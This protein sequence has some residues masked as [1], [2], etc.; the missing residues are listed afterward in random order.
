MGLYLS[1]HIFKID[2][3]YLHLS[4]SLNELVVGL[5]PEVNATVFIRNDGE[6]SYSTRLTFLHPSSLSYRR[7]LLVQ[8]S[9]K[10]SETPEWKGWGMAKDDT[11]YQQ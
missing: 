7:F 11:V 10:K 9:I 2:K 8:V 4:F 6:D 3:D 5:T 1:F